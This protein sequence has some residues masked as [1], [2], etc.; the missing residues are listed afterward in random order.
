[1]GACTCSRTDRVDAV[2]LDPVQGCAHPALGTDHADIARFL[3]ERGTQRDLIERVSPGHGYHIAAP[4]QLQG[5]DGFFEGSDDYFGGGCEPLA[6]GESGPVVDH[7]DVKTQHRA[8]LSQRLAN[9]PRPDNYQ[10]L[11]PGQRVD[12]KLRRLV[13]QMRSRPQLPLRVDFHQCR[14]RRRH[15][16]GEL[17][18]RFGGKFHRQPGAFRIRTQ[19]R[20]LRAVGA[21]ARLDQRDQGQRLTAANRLGHFPR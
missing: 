14:H 1:M 13:A 5:V 16:L 4:I 12:E 21:V 8:K 9:M 19:Q 18:D 7:D 10:A 3:L 2:R 6:V 11:R 17:A 15:Y 20:S